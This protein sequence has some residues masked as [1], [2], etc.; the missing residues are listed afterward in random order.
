MLSL[1][2]DGACKVWGI[3]WMCSVMVGSW[4]MNYSAAVLYS[5]APTLI[6]HT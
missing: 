3:W 5:L 4:I 1:S 6:K 2:R